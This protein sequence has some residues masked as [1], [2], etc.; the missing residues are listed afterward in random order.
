PRR[1]KKMAIFVD[2]LLCLFPFE[3]PYFIRHGMEATFIGHPLTEIGDDDSAPIFP[4]D[5]TLLTVLFGSRTQEVKTLTQ[6]FIGALTLL[7]K[8]IPG[9]H[10]LVPTF[11]RFKQ[12]LKQALDQSGL[13]YQF[14]NQS[15]KTSAFKASKAALAASGTI[16]LELAKAHLPFVIGYKLSPLTYYIAKR[17]ITT[18]YVCLVNVLLN[19][20]FI[21]ECL[22]DRCAPDILS[23]ELKKLLTASEEAQNAMREKLKRSYTH[24]VPPRDTSSM[25]ACDI[26]EKVF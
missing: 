9:L 16:S 12:S 5:K 13:S 23:G 22:Q 2:H 21:A 15:D 11:D 19:E 1:A 8:D 18:P 6:T 10:V 24:L 26:I 17:V 20:P 3:P 7:Q 4:Q 25:M 14:V